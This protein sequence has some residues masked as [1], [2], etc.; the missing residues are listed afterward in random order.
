MLKLAILPQL[1]QEFGIPWRLCGIRHESFPR[2]VYSLILSV[3][4]FITADPAMAFADSPWWCNVVNRIS[5][6]RKMTAKRTPTTSTKTQSASIRASISFPPNLYETLEAI[7]RQKKVSMA[8]VVRDAAEKYVAGQR[9]LL[10][11]TQK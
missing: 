10:R 5:K 2:S 1:K 7:A 3:L 4:L 6:G 8:W 11:E 9:L